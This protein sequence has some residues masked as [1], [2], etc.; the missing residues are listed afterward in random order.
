MFLTS[1]GLAFC[2]CQNIKELI[3]I[4]S[5][6]VSDF[7]ATSAFVIN[8]LSGDVFVIGVLDRE[9]VERVK[10]FVA[11]ED[12]AAELS[13]QVTEATLEIFIEDVNDNDP[14]FDSVAYRGSVLENA[15][16]GTVI[17]KVTA[18][19]VDKNK[20][21]KYSIRGSD[22]VKKLVHVSPSSGDI[23]VGGSSKGSEKIDRE[24]VRIFVEWIL[25]NFYF[26]IIDL[27]IL[28]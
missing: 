15:P 4:D 26:V 22:E 2:E 5:C 12:I 3:V 24:L 16:V 18:D 10:L 28:N 6:Q 11:V 7:N 8:E 21:V 14:V 25:L 20:T 13:P 17:L 19:D 1:N 27:L 9:V 23:S